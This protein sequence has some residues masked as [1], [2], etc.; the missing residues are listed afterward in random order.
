MDALDVPACTF[1]AATRLAAKEEEED[2]L[3]KPQPPTHTPTTSRSPS[4]RSLSSLSGIISS[5]AYFSSSAKSSGPLHT[6]GASSSGDATADL[7]PPSWHTRVGILPGLSMVCLMHAA[8]SGCQG[9]LLEAALPHLAWAAKADQVDVSGCHAFSVVAASKAYGI[10]CQRSKGWA[11]L[12]SRVHN[13]DFVCMHPRLRNENRFM[14]HLMCISCTGNG[15][16]AEMHDS[17]HCTD[18]LGAAARIEKMQARAC[19]LGNEQEQI[20]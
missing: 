12:F 14:L 1:L 17:K 9:A 10:A 8:A 11:Q 13:Q 19:V 16:R 18:L 20:P 15:C 2:L 3:S 4:A 7:L 5:S 6:R